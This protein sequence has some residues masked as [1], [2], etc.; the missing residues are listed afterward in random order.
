[1]S[2]TSSLETAIR[3]VINAHDESGLANLVARIETRWAGLVQEFVV[4]RAAAP[5]APGEATHHRT[6]DDAVLDALLQMGPRIEELVFRLGIESDVRLGEPVWAIA[7]DVIAVAYDRAIPRRA[8]LEALDGV[9][10]IDVEFALRIP[11]DTR[12]AARL[13]VHFR[14]ALQCPNAFPPELVTEMYDLVFD[15]AYATFLAAAPAL[16]ARVRDARPPTEDTLNAFDQL[17]GIAR[18]LDQTWPRPTALPDVNRRMLRSALR[19]IL[20]GQCACPEEVRF[21]FVSAGL[22]EDWVLPTNDAR[23]IELIHHAVRFCE[24]WTDSPAQVVALETRVDGALWTALRS[25]TPAACRVALADF[26]IRAPELRRIADAVRIAIEL[27]DD[28]PIGQC[29][30][31]RVGDLV[32]WQATRLLD[33]LKFELGDD[34]RVFDRTQ[35]VEQWA[36]AMMAPTDEHLRSRIARV[37]DALVN[38]RRAAW[39]IREDPAAPSTSFEGFAQLVDTMSQLTPEHIA[40][41]ADELGVPLAYLPGPQAEPIER[42]AALAEYCEVFAG[43]LVALQ[44]R[45]E[46]LSD[47]LPGQD[48]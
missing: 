23:A 41:L 2:P 44:A 40:T 24:R 9:G 47:A 16:W 25:H 4:R 30:V 36:A 7:L 35:S 31:P 1:V 13:H 32:G 12:Q 11:R 46:T 19:R 17:L 18:R 22:L 3:Q 42:A 15:R 14:L 38:E 6:G 29:A 21:L 34:A 20:M 45:A 10:R 39:R 5:R 27:H 48:C 28:I 8:L 37:F 43:G 26:E 33:D